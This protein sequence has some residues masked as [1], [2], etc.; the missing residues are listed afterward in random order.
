MTTN[1]D[2]GW[3]KSYRRKWRNPVF[4]NF[5]DAAIWSYLT[6]NAAW[7]DDTKVRFDERLVTLQTGQIA[8]SERFLAEGFSCDRQVIRRV[9]AAL[10]TAQMITRQQTQQATII[11]ICNYKQYQSFEEQEKPA[12]DPPENPGQTQG[13]PKYKED[14]TIKK[15]SISLAGW[16]EFYA[17]YPRKVDPGPAKVAYVAA[18]KKT[19]SGNLL[20]AA[21]LYAAD[22]ADTEPKFIKHPKRWL[23][24]ECWLNFPEASL[25]TLFDAPKAESPETE[26]WRVR[27]AGSRK[28]NFWAPEWGPEPGKPG[29]ECPAFL[30][31]ALQR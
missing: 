1:E 31:V 18:L 12:A 28:T 29:C 8:V 30:L 14:K 11:T 16:D 27:L 4:R 7:V 22:C 5:R 17:A 20:R 24:N 15:E 6:D 19:T 13:K 21:A 23:T 2:G 3:A 10:E 26:Q 9:M 25:P